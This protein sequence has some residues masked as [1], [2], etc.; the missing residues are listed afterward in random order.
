MHDTHLSMD[1]NN[2]EALGKGIESRAPGK[3]VRKAAA[4]ARWVGSSGGLA[5][6]VER[7]DKGRLCEQARRDE[8]FWPL[9]LLQSVLSVGAG[10]GAKARG[11]RD[12][13]GL[14]GPNPCTADVGLGGLSRTDEVAGGHQAGC[15]RVRCACRAGLWPVVWNG[16]AGAAGLGVQVALVRLTSDLA[17]LTK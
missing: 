1:R 2:A 8:T 16:A 5:G 4:V 3:C 14:D 10:N 9:K 6:F 15:C 13:L 7:H 17:V 12:V 11:T